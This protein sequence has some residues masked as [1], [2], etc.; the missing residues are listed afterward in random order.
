VRIWDW[1]M[2]H[3]HP[4]LQLSIWLT[5]LL[6]LASLALRTWFPDR[7]TARSFTR[8]FAVVMALQ[9]LWQYVGATVRTR[10]AGAMHRAEQVQQ[11]QNWFHLPSELDVQHAVLAHPWL[12]QAMNVYYATVHID[13]TFLFLFWVWW[14][15]RAAF[16]AVR[17]TLVASTLICL[18]MQMVPVAPPRLL[19]NGGFVDTGLQFGQS[20]Y[21][22]Y[23]TGLASQL[24]AMP[25]IHVAWAFILA[26]YLATLVRGPVRWLGCVHLVV[27][28]LVI[29]G[30]ANHWWLD[31]VVAVMVVLAVLAVQA[32]ARRL[33]STGTEARGSSRVSSQVSTR[34][35]G[36][37]PAGSGRA[38]PAS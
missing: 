19:V 15:H 7:L 24:T 32:A 27:T 25:S 18:L 8:E 21:G 12:V 10:T 38:S 2:Q 22:P 6:T 4:S 11:L 23:N 28:V 29:V 9:G 16:R 34:V 37:I 35:R 26:W 14:R 5:I 36:P 20:V 31:G 13:G 1:G 17:N 3:L 30:T 33:T